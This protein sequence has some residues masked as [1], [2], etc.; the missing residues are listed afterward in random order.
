MRYDGFI[1]DFDGTVAD[2]S[3]GII[4]SV[5][6]ALDKVGAPMLTHEQL[7]SFIGPSLYASFTTTVGLSDEVANK[8][9]A[10]YREHYT[11]VAVYKCRLYDGMEKLLKELSK[12]AKVSVAS[13]KPQP[14]LEIAVK[15]LGV[16]KYAS[17]IVGADLSVKGNDKASQLLRAKQSDRPIMIGDSVHDI[18]SAK[19]VGMPVVAVS[20]GFTDEKTLKKENPDYIVS[21]VDELYKLLTK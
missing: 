11:P 14:Q 7:L 6:Y 1:F 21:S 4:E 8:A 15:H 10:Y 13:A 12:V 18:R 9:V 5:C 19:A 3:E 20:Y 16:D 2:T 17:V